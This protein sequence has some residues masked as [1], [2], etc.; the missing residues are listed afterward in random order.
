[1]NNKVPVE[2]K[3]LND[4]RGKSPLPTYGTPGS[5][6]VDFYAAIDFPMVID[7]GKTV[8]VPTGVAI[9][10]KDPSLALLILP[11]S[12]LGC[13]NRVIPANSP[14][15]IDSDYQNQIFICL[16]NEN[17]QDVF[18]FEPG[19]RIAQ[20]ILIPIYHMEFNVVDEF[21]GKTERTGG[22]GTTGIK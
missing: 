9:W 11:R 8:F 17:E 22:F 5:A 18:K 19:D 20:G 15:L 7:P 2:V 13:K 12:G 6:A 10:V 16:T 14:G 21:S 4:I 3:I 1:M